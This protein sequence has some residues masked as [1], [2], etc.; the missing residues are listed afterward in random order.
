MKEK[1]SWLIPIL[2]FISLL[3][4]VIVF[5]LIPT[6]MIQS[7]PEPVPEPPVPVPPVP[8]P[9]VPEPVPEP[10]PPVMDSMNGEFLVNRLG[11]TV[12]QTLISNGGTI[13]NDL[14]RMVGQTFN[15]RSQAQML[16]YIEINIQNNPFSRLE[17]TPLTL[18]IY[19]TN[20]DHTPSTS[21]L[22]SKTQDVAKGFE[23]VFRFSGL[24]INL[25]PNT[26]YV[27]V[28]SCPEPPNE[29]E[30]AIRWYVSDQ[31]QELTPPLYQMVSS[32]GSA[33]QVTKDQFL[34][35]AVRVK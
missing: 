13:L 4:L 6:L 19:P 9:P 3:I 11:K 32:N 14:R 12:V 5:I 25:N 7:E 31:T 20:S 8:V 35:M 27:V 16:D 18:S 21:L 34:T 33:W 29:E 30:N 1:K 24:N 28:F 10:G 2:F 26:E 15:S 17:K 22:V 23:G